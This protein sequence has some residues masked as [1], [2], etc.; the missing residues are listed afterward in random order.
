MHEGLAA[1]V[2]G[3]ANDTHHRLSSNRPGIWAKL[4]LSATFEVS[5]FDGTVSAKPIQLML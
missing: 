5:G 4:T 3:P 1:D 2:I